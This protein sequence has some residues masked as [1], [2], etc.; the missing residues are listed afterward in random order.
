MNRL[1]RLYAL[2]ELL[3][4]PGGATVPQLA[5]E[6][7]VTER[8]IQR[9]VARLREQGLDVE[10]EPGRGG[11]LRLRGPALPPPLGLSLGEALRLALAHRLSAALGTIPATGTLD[12]AARKLAAGL[13]RDAGLR[14]QA[15]LSRV[16]VGKPPSEGLVLDSGSVLPS[17][18][19]TCEEAF[20]QSWELELDYLDVRGRA[21]HRLV[22]PHGL[23]VQAPLWY[24]LAWDPAKRDRRMFRLDRIRAAKAVR[25]HSFQPQDPRILFE[26]ISRYGIERN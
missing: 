3:R 18:Y 9:D 6:L 2:A 5:E 21:S 23:L 1:D 14:L 15:L 4:R 19:A 16:V 13:P 26:E 10:G 12:L 25:S 24:L 22:E 11:G 7:R 17:V 20:I 8:T